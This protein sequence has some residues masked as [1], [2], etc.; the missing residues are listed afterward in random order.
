MPYLNQYVIANDSSHN[1][2]EMD[3]NSQEL[4]HLCECEQ[5]RYIFKMHYEGIIIVLTWQKGG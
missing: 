4:L 3:R 5:H 2:G 1:H